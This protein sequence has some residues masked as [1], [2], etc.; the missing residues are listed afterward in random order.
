[1]TLNRIKAETRDLFSYILLG[2]PNF[3]KGTGS[4]TEKE[5]ETLLMSI[6]AIMER[7]KD[8]NSRQWLRVCHKAAEQSWRHYEAGN[9]K[10]GRETIQQAEEYF[11]NAMSRKPIEARFI[12]GESG[13]ALDSEK[14]FPS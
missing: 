5:F 1:M 13:A 10:T 14:G 3:P 9:L 8:E 11:D 7:T 12:T 6:S 4:T 2:C